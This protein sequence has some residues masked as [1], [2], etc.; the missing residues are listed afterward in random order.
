[1]KKTDADT[2][3]ECA[4]SLFREK[5][6]KGTSMADIGNATGLLKGSIYYHFESKEDI[7]VAS[8]HRLSLVFEEHMFAIAYED[9]RLASIRLG[10]VLKGIESYFDNYKACVMAHLSLEDISYIPEAERLLGTFFKHWCNAFEHIFLEYHDKD[11]AK[12]LAEDAI[13]R[14]EGAVIW[15]K[16][17]G[18]NGPLLRANIEI[19]SLI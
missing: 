10:E 2:I 8:L 5:G 12:I 6:Y 4:T 7:L 13:C 3:L 19:K 15:L 17:F 18:D 16:L 1:M 11:K 14:I 9:S